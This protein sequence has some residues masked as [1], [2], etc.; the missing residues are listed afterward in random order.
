MTELDELKG[1]LAASRGL[2]A[3][4]VTARGERQEVRQ[5]KLGSRGRRRVDPSLHPVAFMATGEHGHV[6]LSE[7]LE[8][9]VNGGVHHFG[10]GADSRRMVQHIDRRLYGDYDPVAGF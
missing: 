8:V 4:V 5:V 10:P 1:L 6:V 9:R 2:I 3:T 7:V